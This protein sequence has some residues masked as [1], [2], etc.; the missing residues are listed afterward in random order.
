MLE[1]DNNNVYFECDDT[2]ELDYKYALITEWLDN[3]V[4]VLKQHHID[5]LIKVVN[6]IDSYGVVHNDI[7]INNICIHNIGHDHYILYVIDFSHAEYINN[8]SSIYKDIKSI[9]NI[10]T[11]INKSVNNK[12]HNTSH[13]TI[14]TDSNST[15][16]DLSY[17]INSS[18]L[19][20]R[21][22]TTL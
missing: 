8:Q 21:H 14:Y 11:Y 19:Y 4:D 6:T 15:K 3:N 7:K 22:Y 5:G 10:T 20:T 12:E 13:T 1:T 17:Y 18:I 16:I 2:I 9:D